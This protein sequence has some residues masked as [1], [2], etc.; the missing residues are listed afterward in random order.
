[1]YAGECPRYPDDKNIALNAEDVDLNNSLII[2]LSHCWL[3]GWCGAPGYDKRPHPDDISHSKYK[4]CV[5]A[6]Q[7]IKK[8][9]APDIK[10]CHIWM[11]YGC[12]D[13]D[14]D[15][16]GELQHLDKIV[17]I[18]DCLLTPIGNSENES[19]WRRP[20]VSQEEFYEFD[21][22]KAFQWNGSDY[23][24]LNRGWCR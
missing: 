23:S 19:D 2:F 9:L 12:I 6:I 10:D 24:Y 4:L 20:S 5:E 15:P 8:T 14:G 21:Q 11:D 16:A 13:Q 3:R 17:E 7:K 1:M 18:C 22:Y